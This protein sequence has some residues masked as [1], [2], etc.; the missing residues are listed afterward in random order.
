MAKIMKGRYAA[1]TDEPFVV[2]IIGMRINKFLEFK[3]W[4]S[5]ARAMGPMIEVLNKNPQKGYLG[6]Q[7]FLYWP[8]VALVQYWR[9]FEDLENFARSPQEPHLSAW[10]AFHKKISGD[11]SVGIWHETYMVQPGQSEA[12]YD[13]MPIFGLADAT[14]H[15]KA[16]GGKHTAR[17]RLGGDNEP[18]VEIVDGYEETEKGKDGSV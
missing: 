15:V 12:I 1:Q 5:V 14:K 13:N 10:K 16:V 8:G 9:S 2:F 4:L 11:G 7:S 18:P 17:R 3:K 6:G